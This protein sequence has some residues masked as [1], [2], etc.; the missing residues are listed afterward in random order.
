MK[1]SHNRG[2]EVDYNLFYTVH[3]QLF[4]DD[5]TVDYGENDES[6]DDRGDEEITE[7]DSSLERESSDDGQT[8][9]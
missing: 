7:Q 5:K 8:V 2:Q 1:E 6:E 4:S 9:D 3:N